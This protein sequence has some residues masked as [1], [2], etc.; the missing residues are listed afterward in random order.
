MAQVV[1][2]AWE[3]GARL[4][5][6]DEWFDLSRWLRAFEDCGLDPA[7]YANREREEDEV[8][9]FD[10]LQADLGRRFLWAD[11]RRARREKSVEK[12][13][14]GPCAGCDVCND[15]IH[16]ALARDMADDREVDT[17][18]VQSAPAASAAAE[19][20]NR[21]MEPAMAAR[22][23]QNRQNETQDRPRRKGEAPNAAPPPIQRLR[24]TYTKLGALRYLSHLD[25]AK[26][27]GM[28]L[29]RAGLTLAYSQG[30][31]PQPRIQYAPPLSLGMG[32]LREQVD[33]M[34]AR[35][36]DPEAARAALNAVQLDGLTF[37][38]VDA[39]AVGAV[40]L[41]ASIASSTFEIVCAAAPHGLTAED[42]ALARGRFAQATQWPAVLNK[43]NGARDVDLKQ[44]ILALDIDDGA[45]R[46]TVSHRPGLFV[47][48]HEALGLL[49]ERPVELGL[50]V[51][52][53]RIGLDMSA[54]VAA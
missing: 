7:F 46:M 40:S 11:Q 26:V 2:R 44:A 14:T 1:R 18:N 20:V 28:I 23:E 31:N 21:A 32:G 12:C 22:G 36:V 39:I 50:H 30:F 24:L 47:K 34:L 10:H 29:R 54:A 25:F 27:L 9:P 49:L 37:T 43:K 42:L 6:W 48:P 45:L 53:N 33:I 51:R 8:F 16:H 19:A 4:D 35:R 5:G 52:V 15:T 3:L 13:D 41:E 17:A 38:A